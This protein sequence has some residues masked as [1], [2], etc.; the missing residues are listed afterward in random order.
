MCGRFGRWSADDQ[1]SQ[2]F[3]APLREAPEPRYNVAPG[4]EVLRHAA[5]P[6]RAHASSWGFAGA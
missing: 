4:M 5:A 1:L 3:G 6:R 2:L